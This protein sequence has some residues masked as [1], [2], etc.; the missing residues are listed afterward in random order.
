[1]T[2]AEWKLDIEDAVLDDH[3]RRLF[4]EWLA[5]EPEA[6][7]LMMAGALR[8]GMKHVDAWSRK[9]FARLLDADLVKP[10]GNPV[11]A[12]E[13]LLDKAGVE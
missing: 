1:M 3:D 5:L 2:D 13:D 7:P 11:T 8:N 12:L 4:R 10:G 6:S 9:V